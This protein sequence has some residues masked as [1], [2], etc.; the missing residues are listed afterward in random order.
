[1]GGMARVEHQVPEHD[2]ADRPEYALEARD[3]LAGPEVQGFLA[4]LQD[5]L[6]GIPDHAVGSHVHVTVEWQ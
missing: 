6:R 2:P 1:M 5:P 4:G 3:W